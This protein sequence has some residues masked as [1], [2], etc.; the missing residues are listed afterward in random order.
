MW[1]YSLLSNTTD[2]SGRGHQLLRA[3][4]L[5]HPVFPPHTPSPPPSPA[6][7]YDTRRDLR[8]PADAPVIGLVLQRSH[9]VTGDEGHYS[10]VVAELEARGA[11]VVPV[12]AGGLDFSSP[13]KKFF[14]DPLGSGKAFVDTVVSLTGFALVGGP[15]RQDAP[16]AVE[17]LTKLNVPYLV[18]LPLVFQ[19]TEEWLDSELGVHPVQVALQVRALWGRL[20]LRRK[21][22][23][24]LAVFSSCT[25]YC[26]FAAWPLHI[27]IQA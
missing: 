8:L 12:F 24:R 11:R 27:S 26:T 7:R 15:A 1:S 17:A 5:I 2:A 10:G 23:W 3:H 16:K 21:E 6:C 25:V 22:V 19:T 14:Y 9:L 20:C 18:S 13:V 4:C